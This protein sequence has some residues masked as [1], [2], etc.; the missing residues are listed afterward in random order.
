MTFLDSDLDVV[1][2]FSLILGMTD[3]VLAPDI[4]NLGR[5]NYKKIAFKSYKELAYLHPNHF[6]PDHSVIEAFNPER[7]PY[8]VI[9][10][11]NLGAYHDV[12]MKGL[13]DEMA[14]QLIELLKTKGKVFI[15][16]ERPLLQNLKNT[17]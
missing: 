1:R 8:S 13:T 3:Y 4:T 9:R 10:L 14:I 2:Q 16:S 17:G 7:E 11:V 12:G 15:S 5:F 6:V